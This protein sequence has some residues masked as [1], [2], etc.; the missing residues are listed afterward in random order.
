M[1]QLTGMQM[2]AIVS[3]LVGLAWTLALL[4][5]AAHFVVTG[6]R[7]DHYRGRKHSRR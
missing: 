1:T 6:L 5:W 7:D 3:Y 2:D 4:G